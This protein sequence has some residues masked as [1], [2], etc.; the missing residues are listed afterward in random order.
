MK[1]RYVTSAKQVLGNLIHVTVSVSPETASMYLGLG[2][3]VDLTGL[4][5]I[6][7]ILGQSAFSNMSLV[8]R[9][10][11]SKYPGWGWLPDRV[12]KD[13]DGDCSE[14][15]GLDGVCSEDVGAWF[16]VFGFLPRMGLWPSGASSRR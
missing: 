14:D 7:N 1:Y 12:S 15:I 9:G 3:L 13:S 16:R 5:G 2:F 10:P 6:F 11:F 4:D 8:T